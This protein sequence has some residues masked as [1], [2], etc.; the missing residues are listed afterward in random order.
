MDEKVFFI[1]IKNKLIK[2]FKGYLDATYPYKKFYL[3]IKKSL[4]K[5][6]YM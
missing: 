3:L 4:Q 1:T 2:I 6:T 5:V